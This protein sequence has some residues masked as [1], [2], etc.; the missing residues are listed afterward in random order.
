MRV[1]VLLPSARIEDEYDRQQRQLEFNAVATAAAERAEREQ[2]A[3]DTMNQVLHLPAAP[4]RGV[5]NALTASE[6]RSVSAFLLSTLPAFKTRTGER[7]CRFNA[8]ACT[9][10]SHLLCA[11][12][13]VL[14]SIHWSARRHECGRRVYRPCT[15]PYARHSLSDG[16][17]KDPTCATRRRYPRLTPFF[18]RIKRTSIA[19]L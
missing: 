11:C 5:N 13:E 2:A 18:S 16:L 3:L 9:S 8:P 6:V 1:R 14:A 19:A 17:G 7:K 10:A 4:G 15:R 12:S